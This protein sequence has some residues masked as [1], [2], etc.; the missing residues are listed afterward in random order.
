MSAAY[1][2]PVFLLSEYVFYNCRRCIYSALP[3]GKTVRFYIGMIFLYEYPEIL[4]CMK[5]I[6]DIL[7]AAEIKSYLRPFYSVLRG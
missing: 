2:V 1:C 7:L 5:D 4:F 6:S 3:S